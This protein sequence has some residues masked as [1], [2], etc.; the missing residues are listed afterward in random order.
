MSVTSTAC[1]KLQ[2]CDLV[3]VRGDTELVLKRERL[4]P[5]DPSEPEAVAGVH[6]LGLRR[7][8]QDV[9]VSVQRTH[10]LTYTHTN[11]NYTQITQRFG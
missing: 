6:R 1:V 5:D 4:S 2:P 8:I 10:I 3:E 11:E 9:L 7:H